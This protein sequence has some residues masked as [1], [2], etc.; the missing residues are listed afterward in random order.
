MEKLLHHPGLAPKVSQSGF[1]G[2]C[3]VESRDANALDSKVLNCTKRTGPDLVEASRCDHQRQTA[4]PAAQDPGKTG[5][6]IPT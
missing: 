5:Q 1:L 4:S 3:A 2:D 6:M